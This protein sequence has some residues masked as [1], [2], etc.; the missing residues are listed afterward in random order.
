MDSDKL[1][2]MANQILSNLR[3]Y[4]EDKACAEIRQHIHAFWTPH[5]REAIAAEVERGSLDPLV[6]KA[7]KSDCVP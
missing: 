2:H 1:I 7:L 3:G 6:V 4:P 5:M